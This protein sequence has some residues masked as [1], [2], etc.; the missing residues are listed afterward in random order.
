MKNL[1]PVGVKLLTQDKIRRNRAFTLLEIMVS[2]SIF[3][4]IISLMFVVTGRGNVSWSQSSAIIFLHS[5]VR[6]VSQQLTRELMLS[7]PARIF[8]SDTDASGSFDRIRFSVPVADR[9]SGILK[10]TSNDELQWGDGVL[11][12]NAIVYLKKKNNL[13]RRVVDPGS[14][15]IDERIVAQNVED[16]R[17]INKYL[18]YEIKLNFY[19]SKYLEISL[20]EPIRYSVIIAV[21]PRN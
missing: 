7:S 2:F 16:F 8:L 17:L 21:T 3:L 19:I 12:G 14:N 20:A 18:Y 1:I 5:Q 4:I 11:Q 9:K 13:L 10:K 15:V 6:R